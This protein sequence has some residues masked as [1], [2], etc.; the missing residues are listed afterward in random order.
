MHIDG[1]C[2]CGNIT[3]EAEIDPA[4][5]N[6]CH[7][8]DCQTLTGSPYR[9]T[10]A[11]HKDHFRLTGGKPKLY[12]K[13]AESGAGRIQAFCPEC[14]TPI[15]AT[16]DEADPKS[17][18]IRV[19]SARQRAELAPRKQGWCRSAMPWSANIESLPKH[20]KQAPR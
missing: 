9:V 7:C 15:Y 4:M 17:F 8:T 5:V 16:T 3:Y 20:E 6:I 18:G 10:V 13:T 1:G 11:A 12:R 19:G 14:G 2:H